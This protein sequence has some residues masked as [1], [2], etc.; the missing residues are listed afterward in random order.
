AALACTIL[1][2][3]PSAAPE[4][5]RV[6]GDGALAGH[7][8]DRVARCLPVEHEATVAIDAHLMERGGVGGRVR[9][10]RRRTTGGDARGALAALEPVREEPD[11]DVQLARA[12]ALL[13]LDEHE[14]ALRVLDRAESLAERPER[15][16][17]TRA[18]VQAAAGDAEA[19]RETMQRVRSR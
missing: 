14:R 15:V 18:R 9:E 3:R 19:M 12:Q 16:L 7:W 1:E 13:A 11:L 2:R 4:L 6:A 8:L 17:E 10:A 5:L